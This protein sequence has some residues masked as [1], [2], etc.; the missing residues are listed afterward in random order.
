M[1]CQPAAGALPSGQ[2]LCRGDREHGAFA[3][4]PQGVPVRERG[5]G[6]R[7]QPYDGLR[8][9]WRS[10][11]VPC[12]SVAA[13][14]AWQGCSVERGRGASSLRWPP[15]SVGRV[16][17]RRWSPAL[18]TFDWASMAARRLAGLHGCRKASWRFAR[19]TT[20]LPMAHRKASRALSGAQDARRPLIA[21][22]KFRKFDFFRHK[23]CP[24]PPPRGWIAAFRDGGFEPSAGAGAPAEQRLARPLRV[25]PS[26]SRRQRPNRQETTACVPESSTARPLAGLET[27]ERTETDE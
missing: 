22:G 25:A 10:I 20:Q 5:R 19:S 18:R 4:R 1:G 2:R 6:E 21:E 23:G 7:R 11:G 24:P 26:W 27:R 13:A 12:A 9:A 15:A 17:C 3:R 14:S 16:A 8:R